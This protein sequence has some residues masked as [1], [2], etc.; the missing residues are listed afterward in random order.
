[1]KYTETFRTSLKAL[2][3][4][5]VRA[6][7]TMLGVIIGVFAVIALVSI[8]RGLQN[9]VTD[10]F[11][12]LGSNLIYVM[13][14]SDD[15]FQ[16]PSANYLNNKLEAKHV[17]MV[18]RYGGNDLE[19][20]TG[21]VAASAK[22][23][24][25][26][27]TRRSTVYGFD[28]DAD[29]VF[30]IKLENGRY[31]SS[32]E[33]RS[34]AKVALISPTLKED[35]FGD[36][37]AVGKKIKLGEDTYEIIGAF[38]SMGPDFEESFF[39]PITTVEQEWGIE[40]YTWIAAKTKDDVNIDDVMRNVELGVMRDLKDDE[41]SVMSQQDLLESV[42]DILRILA[43]ALGVIAGISLL[44]GGIG[45]MNI[46]L[47]SVNERIRE[48]GLRKAL[49]ATSFNVALQFMIEA[50]LISVSGGI[51]GLF[52]GWIATLIAQNWV[53]AEITSWCVIMALGFSVFVGVAF[54]TY[55]ALNAAKKDPI[56]ALRYE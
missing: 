30:K 42:Q 3:I 8:V 46:M 10:Q 17:D 35:I 32:T 41:F 15:I 56:D 11:D 53:R 26:N 43:I 22:A 13:P 24:Y 40:Q 19:A 34:K 7:L 23:K 33:V 14:G 51:V 1:M 27:T 52:L 28:E 49:G 16:D 18:E 48:I 37:K 12:A 6:F 45:I 4:N 55:P 47:V 5:K 9:Y 20:V 54:G 31:F 36:Q 39:I 25:K 38:E 2:A 44:V 21:T 29:E 50:I